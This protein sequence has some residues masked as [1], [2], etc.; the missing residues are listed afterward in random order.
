MK[1]STLVL[2]GVGIVVVYFV[3]LRKPAVAAT[4]G[5][6]ATGASMPG[7]TSTPV[8]LTGTG[9]TLAGASSLITAGTSAAGSVASLLG[10]SGSS[11]TGM[12][13]YGSDDYSDSAS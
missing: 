11:D 2:L 4:T 5:A 13:S 3:I 6:Y 7:G 8:V 10:S 1:T 9:S 12:G